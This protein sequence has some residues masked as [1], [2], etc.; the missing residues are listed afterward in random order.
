MVKLKKVAE[1]EPKDVPEPIVSEPEEPAKVHP[2]WLAA[3][4]EDY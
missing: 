3:L 4:G 1:E 2:N